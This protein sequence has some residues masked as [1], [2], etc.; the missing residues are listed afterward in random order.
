MGNKYMFKFNKTQNKWRKNIYRYISPLIF[1]YREE[2]EHIPKDIINMWVTT[3]P[4]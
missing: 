2:T 4:E 3:T 1:C